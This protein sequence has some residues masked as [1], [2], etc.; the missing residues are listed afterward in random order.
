MLFARTIYILLALVFAFGILGASL[1][2]SAAPDFAFYQASDTYSQQGF[3]SPVEYY[4]PHHGVLP[5]SP[6]WPVKAMRDK[7]WF[8]L[9]RDSVRRAQLLLLFADKRISMAQELFKNGEGDIGVSTLVKAEQYLE[10]SFTE[11][12]EAEK[13][14]MDTADFLQKLARACLKHREMLEEFKNTAPNDAKPV[15]VETLNIPKNIYEKAVHELNRKGI[16][17]PEPDA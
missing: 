16:D 10:E 11:Y 4:L 7:A 1:L 8:E 5:N 2:R 9:T 13:Q 14:G 12:E 6:L 17:I 15:I 3:I